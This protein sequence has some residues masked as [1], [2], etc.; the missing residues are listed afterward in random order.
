MV[1]PKIIVLRAAGT[2]CDMETE[3]AF[4]LAGGITERVHINSLKRGE[5]KL[6]DYQILAIPGGFSYGDDI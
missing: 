6:K 2:N 3:W 1:K 5:K 4:R